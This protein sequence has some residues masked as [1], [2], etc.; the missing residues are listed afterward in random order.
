M[1]RTTSALSEK[2]SLAAKFGFRSFTGIEFPK[3]V[4]FWSRWEVQKRLEFSHKVDLAASF[5]NINA[6][7][8]GDDVVTVEVSRPLFEL[9]EVFN[10][11][12]C[13]LRSEQALDIDTP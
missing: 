5:E 7:L 12:K 3:H 6:L 9:R 1:T 8:G 11:L 13:P 4:Q 10:C 2:Y